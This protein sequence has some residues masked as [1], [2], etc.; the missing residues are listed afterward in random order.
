MSRACAVAWP[1]A[2][3]QLVKKSLMATGAEISMNRHVCFDR[4]ITVDVFHYILDLRRNTWIQPSSQ[5]GIISTK[6]RVDHAT[7]AARSTVSEPQ[8]TD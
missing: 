1:K 6:L 2:L 4:L 5:S 3:N 7:L 8:K